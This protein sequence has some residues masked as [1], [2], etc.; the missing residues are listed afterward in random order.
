MAKRKK[1]INRIL[2]DMAYTKP[3]IN[4]RM[5]ELRKNFKEVASM[6]EAKDKKR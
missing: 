5:L 3:A 6:L 2:S 1:G 4:S